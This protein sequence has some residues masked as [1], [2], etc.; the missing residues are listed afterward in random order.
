MSLKPTLLLFARG[1][2]MG[3]ADVVPG[4]SGGTIAFITGIYDE[5]L[6]SLKN[7]NPAAVKVLFQ[8]GFGSFWSYINGSFLITLFTGI[9]T[10]LFSLAKLITWLL[11]HHPVLVWSF[12]FG[13]VLV[14]A[15]HVAKQIR[16]WPASTVLPFLV[17]AVLAWVIAGGVPAAAGNEVN[18]FTFFWAGALAICAMILPGISGSFI[19]LLLG[20]YGSV[21]SAVK[22]LDLLVLTVLASGCVVGLLV[23]ARFLSWLLLRARMQ[24]LAFLVGLMLGSLNKIW[25]WKETLTTRVNSK[26]IEVPLLQNNILPFH[27]EQLTGQPSQFALAVLCMGLAIG[28]VLGLEWL[29]DHDFFSQKQS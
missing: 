20:L 27:Y 19:L 14:S 12:F 28:L 26:G 7:C 5:L 16:R 24:T 6:N 1:V 21:L 4:V 9:L 10:S 3:A 2:A 23:F 11:D 8:Q 22:D 17:G 25:P 13:L 18:L 15:W 29:A